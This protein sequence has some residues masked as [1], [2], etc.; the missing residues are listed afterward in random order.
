MNPYQILPIYTAEQIKL[1]KDR[2]IG[3]LPPHIFA[4]GDN[5]YAHMN[6]YGQDQCI[7]IRYQPSLYFFFREIFRAAL[8][9]SSIFFY[10]DMICQMHECLCLSGESG[11]GKTE[12]TKLI[13]QYL[14]AISGKHSWIE[15]QILEANP[16]L[17]GKRLSRSSRRDRQRHRR[18]SS[19]LWF[20]IHSVRQCQDGTKRQFVSLWKIHRHSFQRAR[21]DRRSKNR[22]ISFG[23][24]A[25]SLAKPGREK[26]SCILLYAGW[27]FE[28]REVETGT[29]R[30]LFVQVSNGG[31]IFV[32]FKRYSI[33]CCE[34]RIEGFS[35]QGGSITCEGRDDAA[36]FADIRSAMK[37]LLFSDMEIWEILKLLAALLHMGN[38]KYRAT[39]V[40]KQRNSYNVKAFRLSS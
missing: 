3:E 32:S 19:Y 34:S 13:L 4:I 23:E 6:R 36:E 26:L 21:G 7:V 9:S 1:Y 27:S 2:K 30:C 10:L 5:S 29:G 31:N 38:V 22:A 17:E 15:Q 16:I 18:Y 8:S 11:A 25:N 33:E 39:V 24:I 40:G 35:S 14:A 37:V 20:R 28:R 12:S